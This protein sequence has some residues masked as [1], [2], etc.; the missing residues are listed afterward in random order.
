MKKIASK[1][2]SGLITFGVV[3]CAMS[4]VTAYAA[5]NSVS[6]NPVAS[7][8]LSDTFKL[9]GNV[10][11]GKSPAT[12]FTYTIEKGTVKDAA[13]GITASN[14]PVPTFENGQNSISYDEAAATVDGTKKTIDIQLPEY[15]GVGTYT[16]IIKQNAVTTEGVTTDDKSVTLTVTVVNHTASSDTDTQKFDAYVALNKD[17]VEEKIDA[18]DA[19]ENTYGSA[20]LSVRKVVAGKYADKNRKFNFTVTFTKQDGYS[21]DST[22][23]ESVAGVDNSDFSLTWNGNTAVATFQLADG[24]TASFKNIPCGV[25]YQVEEAA[26]D[27]YAST[28]TNETKTAGEEGFTESIESVVTNTS[29]NEQVNTGINVDN[30][31]YLLVLVGAAIVCFVLVGIKFKKKNSDK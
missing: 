11:D 21:V 26:V 14:M 1:I 9:V 29:T 7:F 6:P 3:L 2:L 10:E 28:I 12:S 20:T 18:S 8:S 19:F 13:T 27:G 31:P 25:S 5:E 17:G 22:I 30:M 4:P 16:Y 15:S 23:S 24:E